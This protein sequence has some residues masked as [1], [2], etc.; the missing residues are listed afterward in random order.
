MSMR[1]AIPAI[2]GATMLTRGG[3]GCAFR[4]RY[5][6]SKPQGPPHR[7]FSFGIN[8][9]SDTGPPGVCLA[10]YTLLRQGFRH[11]EVPMK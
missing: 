2:P 6:P 9:M 11:I 10:L 4:S 1:L 3:V 8:A 7:D 5:S